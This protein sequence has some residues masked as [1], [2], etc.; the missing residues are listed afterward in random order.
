M[1]TVNSQVPIPDGLRDFIA[2]TLDRA[3]LPSC[4]V[5][6]VA[7]TPEQQANAM[8]N[9]CVRTGVDAQ[10]AIYKDAG[11]QVIQ[12]FEDNISLTQTE[13]GK[14][15]VIALMVNKIN[16]LGPQNVSHHC[17]PPD[18]SIWVC[19]IAKSSLESV[20]RFQAAVVG[21]P[22]L[23]K[24]LDENNVMHVEVIKPVKVVS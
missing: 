10:K 12:V 24:L 11:K 16:K 17:L 5:T 6:S 18:A 1:A 4:L 9:N 3:M 23:E 19:D 15:H 14:A 7:R 2:A 22:Q 20:A 13:D 21:H 8:F